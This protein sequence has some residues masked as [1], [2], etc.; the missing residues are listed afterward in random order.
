MLLASLTGGEFGIIAVIS[1]A[2]SAVVGLMTTGFRKR[3]AGE[4]P[5]ADL[6][7]TFA[8]R[9]ETSDPR[10]NSPE[11]KAKATQVVDWILE[12]P[13]DRGLVGQRCREFFD[14]GASISLIGD[15]A[16][17]LSEKW[18]TFCPEYLRDL[19]L[20]VDQFSTAQALLAVLDDMT[21]DRQTSGDLKK[22]AQWATQTLESLVLQRQDAY[23]NA[24]KILGD[25]DSRLRLRR[26][27]ND[28]RKQAERR[29]LD[30]LGSDE[31]AAT[32][33]TAGAA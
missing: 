20:M 19:H 13:T 2:A 22:A 3:N 26:A 7:E 9:A 30:E 32:R 5:T 31:E 1:L 18:P 24:S 17:L 21:V 8:R 11:M 14:S 33:E 10:D 29:A 25:R 16:N 4:S 15:M 23:F 28:E 6:P 12:V 27:M